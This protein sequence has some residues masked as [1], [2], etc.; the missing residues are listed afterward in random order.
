LSDEQTRGRATPRGTRRFAERT[1]T[2]EGHFRAPDGPWIS[3]LGMG[4]RGGEI[5]GAD[6]LLYRSVVPR[7]LERGINVFDTALSYRAQQSERSL[8]AALRRAFAEGRVARDEVFVITK[9]GYLTVDPNLVR[10]RHEAHRY[11]VET[12]VETGLVDPSA[13]VAGSHS[14]GPAFL[15]DQI[16]R[17]RA[18]LGLETIDL[19]CLQEPELQLH[20]HGPDAFRAL[21]ARALEALEE[22]VA[23]GEIAAY[24]ISTWSGLLVP[25]DE[26]GHLSVPEVFELALDVGGPDHHLRGVQLPYSLALGDALGHASQFGPDGRAQSVLEQLRDTG[27]AVFAAAPLVRGRAVRGLPPFVRESFPECRTDAQRCLQFARSSPGVSCSLVGMRQPA[28]VDENAELAGLPPA[29]P[30]TIEALFERVR[31]AEER[32]A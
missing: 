22:A 31:R 13:L 19:Y 20:G 11:L 9:G 28:H 1:E 21:L 30:R 17:S 27:T 25:F 16:R 10:T 23:K 18:N 29:E 6:D 5:G 7:A 2:V 24:G 3:S 32:S 14:L 26:R 4:T 15:R 12:Y 8:G